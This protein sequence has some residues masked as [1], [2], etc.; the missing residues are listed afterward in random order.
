MR[1]GIGG[2]PEAL[3]AYQS[4]RRVTIM[5]AARIANSISEPS[6]KALSSDTSNPYSAPYN[7]VSM[8][9]KPKARAALRK[10]ALR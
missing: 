8:P 4:M 3:S 1:S 9:A 10:T 2:G 5:M 6:T 7:S